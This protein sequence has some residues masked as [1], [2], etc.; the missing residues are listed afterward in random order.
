MTTKPDLGS[1]DLS[2]ADA[3]EAAISARLSGVPQREVAR[4]FGAEAAEL[5][6]LQTRLARH[7][8]RAWPEPRPAFLADLEDRLRR[9]QERPR[10]S[11]L[12]LLSPLFLGGW[13]T[14]AAV[15]AA[16][17]LALGAFLAGTGHG[18]VPDRTPT[19]WAATS[20]ATTGTP[21]ARATE[22]AAPRQVARAWSPGPPVVGSHL[23]EAHPIPTVD[24]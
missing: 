14:A 18:P 13:Q 7:G 12:G 24:G 20:T 2:T 11:G 6:A 17:V 19:A 22:R 21:A 4:A 23:L 15:A 8:E 3:L 16:V 9:E 5:A 1:D 10:T